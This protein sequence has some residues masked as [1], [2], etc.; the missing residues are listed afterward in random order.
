[1]PRNRYLEI[2]R[3]LHFNNNAKLDKNVKSFKIAPLI[4]Q[5]N[6]QIL[7][8]QVFSKHISIDERMVRYY[9]HHYMKQFIS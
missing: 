4:Q 6:R 2:K 3:N 8:F 7:Q 1:M 9:G 5:M